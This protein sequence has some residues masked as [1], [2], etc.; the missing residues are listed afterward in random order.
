M[1]T[2]KELEVVGIEIAL[3]DGSR[4]KLDKGEV[5]RWMAALLLYERMQ[6]IRKEYRKELKTQ[7]LLS[8]LFV[9]LGLVRENDI[10]WNVLPLIALNH[11]LRS[12]NEKRGGE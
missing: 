6:K 3:E 8:E 7:E 2:I 5:E 10:N 11:A 12:I 4:H 9:K 1:E